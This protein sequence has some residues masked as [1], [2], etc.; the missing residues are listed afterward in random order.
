MKRITSGGM[1]LGLGG[2]IFVGIALGLPL[3]S[4]QAQQVS[5]TLTSAHHAITPPLRDLVPGHAK[6]NAPFHVLPLMHPVPVVG[7]GTGESGSRQAAGRTSWTDPDLVPPL[8][9]TEGTLGSRFQGISTNSVNIYIPPDP[10]LSPSGKQIVQTVNVEYAVWKEPSF[11]RTPSQVLAPEPMHTIFAGL[12]GTGSLCATVDGGD[13]IVRWDKY[14]QR[15]I[16]SQLAYNSRLNDDHWCLAISNTSDATG[17]YAVYDF[18]FGSSFPDYPKVGIWNAGSSSPYSGV[19]VS[20]NIFANGRTFEGAA[21][22]GIPLA[23]VLSPP[24]SVTLVC[25]LGSSSVYSIL[26]ADVD[27]ANLPPDEPEMYMQF[28]ASLG[29]GNTLALYRFKPDFQSP[30]SSTLT[31]YKSIGVATYHEACGGGS[32]IP[33]PGTSQQL[34]SLGDRLMYRLA[35]RNM[36]N[37]TDSLLVNHSVQVSSADNQTGVRWYRVI[38][39]TA[40]TSVIQGTYSPDSATYRWMG[41]IAEDQYGDI[42]LGYSVS[43]S[44]LYPGIAFSGRTVNDFP[45]NALD[46]ETVIYHG[47][48][49]QTS[50]NRWGD[51]T[52]TVLDPSDDCTFWYTSEYEPATG[53]FNWKTVI[54]SF[55]FPS[56]G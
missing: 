10:N 31:L 49:S 56:C 38:D 17:S 5:M 39:P 18:D 29:I 50:Y 15:W 36:G 30:A 42:G 11:G 12:S 16:V 27:G 33:Q 45:A 20:F 7:S 8:G 26:P 48:G 43:S 47:S 46:D 13:P 35:Y 9:I 34:D 53:V 40:S 25:V 22:C 4:A 19:Y 55:R 32:C 51:Y 37:G 24:S 54:A 6:P 2:L 21:A 52:S 14:D 23:D 3:S 41:S 44:A 28:V 1:R